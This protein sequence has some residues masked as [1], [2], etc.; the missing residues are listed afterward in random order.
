[1]TR[2]KKTMSLVR[3]VAAQ[4]IILAV[5]AVGLFHTFASPV[6]QKRPRIRSVRGMPNV[7]Q[8]PLPIDP[9]ATCTVTPAM[10]ATWFHTGSVTLNGLVNPANSL[11]FPNVPNCSFYQWSEQMFLWLT[12]PV[13]AQH[14]FSTPTF[15]DVSPVNGAG[16]RT[17]L[18][19]PLPP[20]VVNVEP[21]QAD[22]NVLEAQAQ[23]AAGGSLVYYI[24]SVNDVYAFLK[25]GIAD[26]AIAA[27]TFPTTGSQL[28]NI[29]NFATSKGVTIPDANALAIL[30]KSAWVEASQLANPASY[31]TTT[32]TIP[33][34]N[35]SNPLT[36]TPTG[37]QTVT[38]AL[39]G[40]HVVGST[41]GHPEL[42]WATFEHV[43]NAPRAEYSY[44]N[45][46]GNT[47]TVDPDLTASW[48]FSPA[49]PTGLFNQAHMFYN[50]PNIVNNAG[51]TIS[52]SNTIRWKSFGAASDGPPNPLDVSPGASNSEIIS[53]N[54]NVIGMLLAGDLR[55]NYVMTGSTWTIGGAGPTGFFQSGG[56]E[57]GTSVL[58]NSTAETYEQGVDNT[59]ANGGLNCF[60]CHS[61][62]GSNFLVIAHDWGAIQPLTTFT[63]NSGYSLST[64]SLGNFVLQEGSF[65]TGTVTVNP[66][67]GFSGTVTLS[68]SNLP[69][70]ITA[71]FSPKATSTVSKFTLK[72]SSSA[73]PA[74][75][76]LLIS[77]E[78]GNLTANAS[79]SLSVIGPTFD[80]SAAPFA[81]SIDPNGIGTSTI[82]V[83]PVDGFSGSVTLNASGLPQGV[84]ASFNPN[85]T[86]STSTLTLT[87]GTTAPVGTITV[88]GTS[89]NLSGGAVLLLTQPGGREN[90]GTVA[91]SR[92]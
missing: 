82:T 53:I 60:S 33:T 51:F 20:G 27:N 64:S 47:V 45:N 61:N 17:L 92:Q 85:P 13:G 2:S 39:V 35:Q 52:P 90:Q 1:M 16:A 26:G 48:L 5:A 91:S 32:A 66:R 72:A 68:A 43:E 9:Q 54:D 36:W 63:Q 77:G 56:N 62:S 65:V 73:V 34:Y 6:P 11:T 46:L 18:P 4:I 38:L 19:H 41:A 83:T 3:I 50:P 87:A 37:H 75:S 74:I 25:T 21:N 31:I 67:N 29:T 55:S 89:A 14:V 22:F 80:L 7:T 12:S 71:T 79:V 81:L 49:N 58:A 57:V 44:V 84:T 76:T 23:T 8:N 86:T 59:R 30:V 88:T 42:I 28:A 69:K 15:F 24:T 78:S 40:M 70:G 10:F